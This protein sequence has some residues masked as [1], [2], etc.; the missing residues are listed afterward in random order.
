M[1]I[2][3]SA[4]L[5]DKQV[6]GVRSI[7]SMSGVPS[8]L[9]MLCDPRPFTSSNICHVTYMPYHCIC[10]VAFACS[11]LVCC[12]CRCEKHEVRWR[13][14]KV[15]DILRLENN[16]FITV[17]VS[18]KE[19]RHWLIS[20]SPFFPSQNSFFLLPQADLLLLSSSEPNSLVY[21][22]TAELDGWEHFPPFSISFSSS[23]SLPLCF[24][25]SCL[26]NLVFSE[27]NLKVR[28]AL[29]E[30]AEMKDDEDYLAHFDGENTYAHSTW[31]SCLWFD[32]PIRK[33]SFY[34]KELSFCL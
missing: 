6:C 32:M 29:P 27:T 14:V 8:P 1:Q 22:E 23:L 25:F 10:H 3:W 5:D 17:S 7:L 33:C 9:F 12:D 34:Q 28:Q 16:D 26:F 18:W 15:G 19:H 30:T 11:Y 24:S 21:I 2:R 13:Q 31:R 20:S 4:R